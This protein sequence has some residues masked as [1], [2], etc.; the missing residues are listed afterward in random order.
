MQRPVKVAPSHEA[1]TIGPGGGVFCLKRFLCAICLMA[2][3]RA[4]A[5]KPLGDP[6]KRADA[7]KGPRQAFE[8]TAYKLEASGHGSYRGAN[9][10]Q[11]LNLEFDTREA[12]LQSGDPN[13]N[14]GFQLTGLGY[15]EQ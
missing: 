9:P 10:A 4:V 12:R 14:V 6:L 8:R 13:A 15:G 3:P 2:L 11:R 7:D 5:E 1:G